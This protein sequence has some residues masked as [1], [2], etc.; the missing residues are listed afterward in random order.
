MEFNNVVLEGKRARLVPMEKSHAAALFAGAQDESIW[1]HMP[2]KIKTL[3]DMKALVEAALK[4]RDTGLEYP[5]VIQE[6][7][8]EQIVGS[9]RFLDINDKDR[10]LEIGWTWI[11]PRVWGSHFNT[12][13]KYLLLKHCF[14]MQKAIRVF[15]K[16]D[17][18]NLRSQKAIAKIGGVKEGV[19]RNHR[20]RPDGSFRHS[21]YFSIIDS[22]WPGVEKKLLAMMGD[23][24]GRT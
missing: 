3:A 1:A 17:D 10:G 21:V 12:E 8:G 19:L 22:E 2:L 13:C 6:K 14:E 4:A 7:A 23:A 20:I 18:R 24:D 16:T 15:F 5:F 11:I 9:T